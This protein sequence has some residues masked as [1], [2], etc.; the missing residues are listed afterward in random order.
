[1]G[2]AQANIWKLGFFRTISTL[3]SSPTRSIKC[4]VIP[5]TGIV[6]LDT[7]KLMTGYAIKETKETK[8]AWSV[9]QKLKL[10]MQG[11]DEYVLPVSERT[12]VP[13][14]PLGRLTKEDAAKLVPLNDV[15]ET[16]Y[17]SAFSRVSEENKKNA[18]AM[19][20]QTMLYVGGIIACIAIVVVAFKGCGG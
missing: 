18:N 2:I 4:V 6:G 17:D 9:I 1:M 12:R 11:S 14:D 16:S 7:L 15:A 13:L 8:L 5:E 20:L 3:F 10:S 19:L